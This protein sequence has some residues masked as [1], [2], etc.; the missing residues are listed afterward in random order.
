MRPQVRETDDAPPATTILLADDHPVIRGAIRADLE[1]LGYEICG[2]V[3]DAPA[4]VAA[5]ILLRPGIVLLD[6]DMPGNGITAAK[7]IS[8]ALP[9]TRVVMLTVS[10]DPRDVTASAE[11]GAVGFVLKDVEPALLDQALH[12]A[13]DGGQIVPPA[14]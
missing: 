8:E 12:A 13:L 4:A 10:R 5:A 2:E 3:G 9:Q 6:I 14:R 11:A 1:D 7:A